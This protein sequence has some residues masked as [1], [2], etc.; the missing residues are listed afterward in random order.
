M[1]LPTNRGPWNL[2]QM[3]E[4]ERDEAAA[5]KFVDS[6]NVNRHHLTGC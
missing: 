1:S 3:T 6:M 5:R 2:F 4:F